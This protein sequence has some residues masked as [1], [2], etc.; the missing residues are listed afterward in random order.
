MGYSVVR[1]PATEGRSPSPSFA[2]YSSAV[3]RGGTPLSPAP[4]AGAGR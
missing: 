1:S 2:R 4:L 3:G